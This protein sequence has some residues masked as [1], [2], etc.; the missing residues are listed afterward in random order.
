MPTTRSARRCPTA[1]RRATRSPNPDDQ[2]ALLAQIRSGTPARVEGRFLMDFLLRF[3]AQLEPLWPAALPAPVAF[4]ALTDTLPPKAERYVHRIRLVDAAGHVSAGAAIAP[5]IVRVP[6]L[7]S[8]APPR[9]DVPSSERTRSRVEA[10]VRD[11]FDLVV[12]ACCSRAVEDAA[13][14]AERQPADARA[15]AAAAE[16]PR[17]LPERRPPPAAR[18][19][20]AARPAAVLDDRAARSRCP[21]AS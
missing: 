15:A 18:R 16:P 7:R 14:A 11:A 17:P 6:S 5:Q 21:T 12:G 19:R 3:A 4:G 1:R 13:V 2:A 20:H 8:P 9:L 10:R